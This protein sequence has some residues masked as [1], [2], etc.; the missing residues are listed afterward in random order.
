LLQRGARGIC[1]ARVVVALVLPDGVLSVGRRLVDRSRD[2]TGRRVGFLAYVDRAGFEVHAAIVRAP[3]KRPS[4]RRAWSTGRF[5]NRTLA[6][7]QTPLTL[8]VPVRRSKL[9]S[10]RPTIRAQ[11]WSGSTE[12][13]SLRIVFCMYHS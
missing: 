5:G 8:S 13:L 12:Y 7:A 4:A 11:R 1:D 10:M 9:G 2:R 6:S 3:R